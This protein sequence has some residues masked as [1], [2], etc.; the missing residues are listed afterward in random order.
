MAI[1]KTQKNAFDAAVRATGSHRDDAATPAAIT[2]TLGF[3]PRR[4]V[5]VNV[6]TIQRQEWFDGMAAASAFKT[7]N[8]GTVQQSLI[9]SGGITV[10]GGTV[11]LP[12]PAQNDQVYWV[13]EA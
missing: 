3:T 12:A 7:V 11:T 9:T 6:T 1:V 13:A 5:M 4:V 10:S 8:S 2:L